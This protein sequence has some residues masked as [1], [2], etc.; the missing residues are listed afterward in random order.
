MHPIHLKR[1]YIKYISSD[2]WKKKAILFK[3]LAKNQ[4]QECGSTKNLQVHHLNYDNFFNET[5]KDIIILCVSCHRKRHLTKPLS[6][7]QIKEKDKL[8][9]KV[10]PFKK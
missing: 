2:K 1:R 5:E 3:R 10:N 7:V 6:L 4:C 9:K 8:W